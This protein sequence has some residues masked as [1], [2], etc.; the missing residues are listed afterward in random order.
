MGKNEMLINRIDEI[1]SLVKDL[2]IR[3]SVLEG[4]Y[5]ESG[6]YRK[7]QVGLLHDKD[8]KDVKK[9]KYCGGNMIWED[10]GGRWFPLHADTPDG[11]CPNYQ[12]RG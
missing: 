1:V 7:E 3:V 2:Q 5:R 8:V 10:R 9:C 12:R 4:H 6:G 11:N